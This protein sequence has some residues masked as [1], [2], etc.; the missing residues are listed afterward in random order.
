M[1]PFLNLFDL[2]RSYDEKVLMEMTTIYKRNLNET[3]IIRSP[4]IKQ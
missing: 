2:F 3:D 4:F 1:K